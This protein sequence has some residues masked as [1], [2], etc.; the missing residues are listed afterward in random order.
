MIDALIRA[1]KRRMREET[2]RRAGQHQR[3]FNKGGEVAR[4]AQRARWSEPCYFSEQGDA[5]RLA[6]R[7]GKV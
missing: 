6:L 3:A 4:K 1:A 7:Q 2:N 5:D